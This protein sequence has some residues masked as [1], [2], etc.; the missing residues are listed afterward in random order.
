MDVECVMD[1]D[2]KNRDRIYD[3]SRDNRMVT[4]SNQGDC[5]PEKPHPQNIR[6]KQ[7]G[8]LA[9]LGRKNMNSQLTHSCVRKD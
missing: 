1:S 5:P 4:E 2:T 6:F 3:E 9:N 8:L 7:Y